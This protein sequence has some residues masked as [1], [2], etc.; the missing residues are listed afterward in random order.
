MRTIAFQLILLAAAACVPRAGDVVL[1]NDFVVAEKPRP[2]N[3]VYVALGATELGCDRERVTVN[4]FLP[5]I[6]I[7]GCDKVA[8]F[9]QKSKTELERVGPE[10]ALAPED[11]LH[12]A[13]LKEP[14]G[15]RLVPPV[16][17]S[18]RD[19]SLTVRQTEQ[20]SSWNP[21]A[22]G[23]CILGVNG[24]LHACL[25]LAQDPLVGEVVAQSLPTRL[26][27]PV[28]ILGGPKVPSPYVVNVNVE[29]P[30]PNCR[31]L[32]SPMLRAQCERAVTQGGPANMSNEP[33]S[34]LP[35]L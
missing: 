9:E 1:G 8:Y 14:P 26:Y 21:R 17:L 35:P 13:Q 19:P 24:R 15:T 25:V 30:K 6:Q 10:Y 3:P 20:L 22:K 29:V 34:G 2:Q 18:G 33:A 5:V 31:H 32:S 28:T 12:Q 7:S 27:Q 16:Q 11:D 23:I 4:E